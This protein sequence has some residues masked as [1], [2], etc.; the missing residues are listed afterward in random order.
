M[1]G[2]CDVKKCETPWIIVNWMDAK[3]DVSLPQCS[4]L[5]WVPQ[6]LTS[7]I[8]TLI[9]IRRATRAKTTPATRHHHDNLSKRTHNYISFVIT[10]SDV[11]SLVPSRKVGIWGHSRS[12]DVWFGFSS[13]RGLLSWHSR[14]TSVKR[15]Q[16]SQP[17]ALA[18]EEIS[19]NFTQIIMECGS[20]LRMKSFKTQLCMINE[21]KVCEQH[22]Q[23]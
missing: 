1:E 12:D 16:R 14:T 11:T 15:I 3:S 22:P 20:V 2:G 17:Q 23:V 4:T 7:I 18:G 8:M 10:P 19:A 13:G 9:F 6:P 21:G 5:G